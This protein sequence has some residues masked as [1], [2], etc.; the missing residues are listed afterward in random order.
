MDD[1]DRSALRRFLVEDGSQQITRYM[2]VGRFR[3]LVNSGS[4]HMPPASSFSDPLEGHYS[5]V[6]PWP[7]IAS[8]NKAA[9]VISCWTTDGDNNPRMWREYGWSKYAVAITTPV[10]TLRLLIGAKFCII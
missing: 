5:T 10:D 8:W 2:P 9:T 7:W 6:P 3:S 4:I 1:A